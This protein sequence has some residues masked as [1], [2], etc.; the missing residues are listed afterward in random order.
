MGSYPPGSFAWGDVQTHLSLQSRLANVPS[1]VERLGRPAADPNLLL[2]VTS[3]SCIERRAKQGFTSCNDS[4]RDSPLLQHSSSFWEWEAD[5]S[6]QLKG[7]YREAAGTLAGDAIYIRGGRLPHDALQDVTT[8]AGRAFAL[9]GDHWATVHEPNALTI[10]AATQN[11]LFANVRLRNV[12]CARQD[13]ALDD[14]TV[15][16]GAY[17]RDTDGGIW[18][19]ANG[20]WRAVTE[21]N[22]MRGVNDL[23]D[24]PLV[25]YSPRLRLQAPPS[26][27]TWEFEQRASDGT[28]RELAWMENTAGSAWRTAVDAW[29]RVFVLDN[30]L[31]AATAA[32]LV[33]LQSDDKS[34]WLPPESLHVIREPIAENRL[35]EVTDAQAQGSE[36]TVRCD[37]DSAKVFVGIPEA[38]RDTGMFAL[39][40]GDPFAAGT[41]IPRGAAPDW[42]WKL[43]GRKD[44]ARGSL[45]VTWQG[46]TLSLDGGQFAFDTLTSVALITDDVLELATSTG[47]WYQAPRQALPVAAVARPALE[48]KVPVDAVREGYEG[49]HRRLC[50]RARDDQGTW[51]MLTPDG[52]KYELADCPAYLGQDQQ[53]LYGFGAA[54]LVMPA[55]RAVG[56]TGERSLVVGR[57]TDNIVI[58]PPLPGLDA[59]APGYWLPTAAGVVRLDEGLELGAFYPPP[60]NGMAPQAAPR[61]LVL[62]ADGAPAYVAGV[63]L[64]AL[65][66]TR[67]QVSADALPT[68]GGEIREAH[69]G[70]SGGWALSWNVEGASRMWS[71]ALPAA[72][73]DFGWTVD[74]TRLAKFRRRQVD[75]QLL[76][77]PMMISIHGQSL[78]VFYSSSDPASV[79]LPSDFDPVNGSL[80]GDRLLLIGSKHLYDISLDSAL[81]YDLYVE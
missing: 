77:T 32:G 68:N 16:A 4:T 42:E 51:V 52:P 10:D 29:R 60:F 61:A 66:A 78:N 12:H 69:R 28:W 26:G 70:T 15:P 30:Q 76:P 5:I 13:V 27:G 54:G 18:T 2:A 40:N 72:Q 19:Y 36:L 38:T 75:W 7:R 73:L 58:G 22:L 74:V 45:E 57:F 59:G 25:Y 47:G 23:I 81:V 34:V 41:L 31:W 11:F 49:A 20:G 55:I 3:T 56:G 35:C 67:K 8:C 33:P 71:L 43:A 14:V 80:V 62:L 24:R 1:A 53:W 65:D 79:P 6:G 9:W 17:L 39:G 48:L 44:G 63:D 64:F 21:P 46:E 37:H 50:L